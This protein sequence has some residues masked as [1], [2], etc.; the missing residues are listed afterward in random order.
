MGNRIKYKFTTILSQTTCKEVPIEPKELIKSIVHHIH[1]IKAKDIRVLDL[2]NIVSYCGTFI[3]CTANST[4]QVKAIADN[5]MQS[6]KKEQELLP[7]G[8]EGKHNN[9][10]ILIDYEEVIVH[11]FDEEAR[12]FYTLDSLWMEAPIV[13]LETFDID[14]NEQDSDSDSDSDSGYDD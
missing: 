8:V 5:V 13:P 9:S 4:R 12:D 14:P 7:L 6:L 11:I 2:E 3:L 1:A 10:W